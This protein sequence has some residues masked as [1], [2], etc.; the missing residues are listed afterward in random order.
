MR[1][2][3]NVEILFL[4][5]RYACQ[6]SAAM[7]RGAAQCFLD[8][9][10]ESKLWDAKAKHYSDVMAQCRAEL[11]ELGIEWSDGEELEALPLR[12]DTLH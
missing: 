5:Y 3:A 1:L 6:L 11:K 4:E 9:N 10:P 2:P 7:L 8:V 12:T